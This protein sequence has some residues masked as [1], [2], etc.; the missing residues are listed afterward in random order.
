MRAWFGH[1]TSR[2]TEIS[3]RMLRIEGSVSAPRLSERRDMRGNGERSSEG[4]CERGLDFHG[5]IHSPKAI[6]TARD[7]NLQKSHALPLSS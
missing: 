6:K 1:K 4:L 5:V 7:T 2:E 3:F